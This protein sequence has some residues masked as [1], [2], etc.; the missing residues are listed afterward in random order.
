M[1]KANG[2]FDWESFQNQFFNEG[3]WRNTLNNT[4]G[5]IPWVEDYVKT[6]L[7]NHI[8]NS[9]QTPTSPLSP[10]SYN[11]F[12]THHFVLV[13]ILVPSHIEPKTLS[14]HVSPIEL[15]VHG[16]PRNEETAIRLPA[17]VRQ[18][19]SKAVY[20]DRVLEVRLPKELRPHTQSVPIKFI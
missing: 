10:V 13:K 19:G 18:N 20:K 8:P 16:L 7:S 6:L 5:Q 12:E 2:G 11:I 4:T 15:L 3:I 1:S 9:D 14:L 17:L